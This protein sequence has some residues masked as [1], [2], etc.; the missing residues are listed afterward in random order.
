MVVKLLLSWAHIVYQNQNINT[1][2]NTMNKKIQ[3]SILIE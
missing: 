2:K 1:Y 3:L